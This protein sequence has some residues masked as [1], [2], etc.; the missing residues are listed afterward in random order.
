MYRAL[1]VAGWMERCNHFIPKAAGIDLL[2]AFTFSLLR[3]THCGPYQDTTVHFWDGPPVGGQAVRG[4]MVFTR[5]HE[6]GRPPVGLST[7]V[8]RA[9]HKTSEIERQTCSVDNWR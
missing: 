5:L 9:P 3:D 7:N 1:S 2:I 4:K 6:A 8:D